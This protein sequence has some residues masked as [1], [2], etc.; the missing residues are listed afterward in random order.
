MEKRGKV[1]G[2]VGVPAGNVV[3]AACLVCGH[4]VLQVVELLTGLRDGLAALLVA[5][6][7]VVVG[8]KRHRPTML[9]KCKPSG[10]S[11]Q[12]ET[13]GAAGDWAP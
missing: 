12:G 13:M 3:V 10:V 6:V 1:G 7:I 11:A 9:H 4:L 2:G 5:R 8:L